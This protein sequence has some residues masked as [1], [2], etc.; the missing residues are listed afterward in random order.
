MQNFERLV[1]SNNLASAQELAQGNGEHI[2]LLYIM[3]TLSL[4]IHIRLKI[5]RVSHKQVT[6]CSFLL[7]FP[8]TILSF[9]KW[10][11]HNRHH[12]FYLTRLY[13]YQ[14]MSK[15]IHYGCEG[16]TRKEWDVILLKGIYNHNIL[17]R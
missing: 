3:N 13:G 6:F 17:R 9:R 8:P 1:C 12:P 10:S 15:N 4:L 2:I 7:F 14:N 5:N 16:S 11:W